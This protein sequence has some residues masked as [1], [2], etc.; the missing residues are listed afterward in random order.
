MPDVGIAV[1]LGKSCGGGWARGRDGCEV[2]RGSVRLHECVLKPL[3]VF[4]DVLIYFF[5]RG[6]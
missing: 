4:L 2:Y 1:L 5:V 6:C 3:N